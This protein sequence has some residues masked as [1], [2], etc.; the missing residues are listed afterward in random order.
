MDDLVRSYESALTAVIEEA[1]KFRD[2]WD[3]NKNTGVRIITAMVESD[4]TLGVNVIKIGNGY[5]FWITRQGEFSS[6]KEAAEA[7]A[8]QHGGGIRLHTETWKDD[9][10]HAIRDPFGRY[11]ADKEIKRRREQ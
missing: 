8:R 7:I 2:F 3:E 1:G 5:G 10:Y 4:E 11:L 6:P 9:F